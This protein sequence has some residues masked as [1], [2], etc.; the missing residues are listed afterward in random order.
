MGDHA[1]NIA[2]RSRVVA[3]VSGAGSFSVVQMSD[4]VR[5]YFGMLWTAS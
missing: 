3:R 4:L 2:Q 1:V 5:K